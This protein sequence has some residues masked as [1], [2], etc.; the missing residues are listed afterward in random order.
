MWPCNSTLSRTSP[1]TW[2]T[3]QALIQSLNLV[4][5]SLSM[6]RYLRIYNLKM[7]VKL[8]KKQKR[9]KTNQLKAIRLQRLQWARK[10][11]QKL[12]KRKNWSN[13]PSKRPNSRKKGKLNWKH[14]R[15]QSEKKWRRRSSKKSQQRLLWSRMRRPQWRK[16]VLQ[17]MPTMRLR[18]S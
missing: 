6:K 11:R 7:M 3:L 17:R 14:R 8:K 2:T 15:R 16:K 4:E 9:V 1:T 10:S 13:L 12:T 5:E 18:W